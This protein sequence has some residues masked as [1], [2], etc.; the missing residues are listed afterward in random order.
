MVRALELHVAD[1]CLFPRINKY[2]PGSKTV[3]TSHQSPTKKL[4]SQYN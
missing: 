4:V 1:L 2:K 3:V